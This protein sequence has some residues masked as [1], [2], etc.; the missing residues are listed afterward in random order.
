[1]YVDKY[2]STEIISCSHLTLYEV[3]L[4]YQ[5]SGPVIICEAKELLEFLGATWD[6]KSKTAESL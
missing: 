5:H 1:M 6:R 4:Q 3:V 2:Y